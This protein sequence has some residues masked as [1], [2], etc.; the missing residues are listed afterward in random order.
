MRRYS[1]YKKLIGLLR[2]SERVLKISPL[3]GIRFPVR[4]VRSEY[5]N[6]QTEF[7][8]NRIYEYQMNQQIHD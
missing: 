2:R 3:S 7:R 4:P 1:L 6:V 5:V 8:D